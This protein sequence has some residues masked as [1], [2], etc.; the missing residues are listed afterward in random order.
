ME[1]TKLGKIQ[2]KYL[3]HYIDAAEPGAAENYMRLGGDLEEYIVEL[4]AQVDKKKNILGQTSTLISGYEPQAS[5]EP[6]YAEAGT[7]LFARL[8]KIVEERLVLDDLKTSV[9]DVHLWTAELGTEFEAFREEAYIEPVSYGGDTTGYQI[10]FN[11]HLTGIRTKGTF[12]T[13]ERTFTPA[14]P[15]G[16]GG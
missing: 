15:S 6:Y 3:A 10:P 4:S 7:P 13:E 2:R 9:L 16:D 14:P 5:V 8:Q 1:V 11:I 12:D